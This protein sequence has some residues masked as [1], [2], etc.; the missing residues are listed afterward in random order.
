MT[1][2]YGIN[3]LSEKSNQGQCIYSRIIAYQLEG[4]E[5]AGVF[6]QSEVKKVLIFDKQAFAETAREIH[7]CS[8]TCRQYQ[9]VIKHVFHGLILNVN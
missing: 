8:S 9:F 3:Y 2:I 1:Y 4:F 6:E 7:T 5:T